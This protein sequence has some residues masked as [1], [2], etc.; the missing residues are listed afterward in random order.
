M[1]KCKNGHKVDDNMKFCTQCGAEMQELE[2][3]YT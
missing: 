3:K 1:K 2:K